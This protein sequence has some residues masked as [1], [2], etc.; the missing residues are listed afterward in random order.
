MAAPITPGERLRRDWP[1]L[2]LA[3]L[4][5]AL[6]LLVLWFAGRALLIV[7]AAV[8][9]AT[10]LHAASDGLARLTGLGRRWCLALVCLALV[11]AAAVAAWLS[12]PELA[13]QA[14]ELAGRARELWDDLRQRIDDFALG[15]RALEQLDRQTSG[16]AGGGG[17]G[18]LGEVGAAAE[19]AF[20]VAGS[21]V[22]GLTE[23]GIILILGLYLAID[24]GLY[25]RGFLRLLPLARRPRARVILLEMAHTLRDWLLGQLVA[26]ATVGALTG[27]GLWLIG[28]PQALALGIV[29]GL[30]D[31][32]P[33]VGP[34]LASVPGILAAASVGTTQALYALALYIA[35]QTAENN[36][37][38]PIVQRRA[39][40]L[41]PALTMVAL[42]V[43]GLLGGVLGLLLAVPLAAVLTVAV[44]M[45]YVEDVLGDREP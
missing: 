14:Q 12:A 17:G 38:T 21:V 44:R 36:L 30:L 19:R 41:P 13:R 7:G 9:V 43:M 5:T 6:A 45:A 22:A 40:D 8:L 25:L 37:I 35:I 16:G 26:M 1:Y 31:F 4:V 33:N 29:A 20:S 2:V 32:I 10:V 24:P 39:V 15:R 27:M 28:V 3:G 23:L 34:I 42:L 11:G 18:A